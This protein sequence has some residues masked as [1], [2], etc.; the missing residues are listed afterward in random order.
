MSKIRNLFTPKDMTE[1]TPW[2]RIVGFAIP[3]LLGNVA[4]QLY[5]TAGFDYC[6]QICG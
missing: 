2:K 3:L 1:G 4:Q 6:R 5:N